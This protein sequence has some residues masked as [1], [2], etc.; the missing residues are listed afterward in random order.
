MNILAIDYGTKKSGIA[1]SIDGFVFAGEI[2]KSEQLISTIEKYITTKKIDH[3]V[4][5]MPYNIDGSISAH[6]LKV[7]KLNHK[8]SD[9]FPNT[10]ISL[11]DERCSTSEAMI[12]KDTH[13]V[14]SDNIDDIA[15]CIILEDY[16]THHKSTLL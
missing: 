15:A 14:E 12:W 16:I 2:I 4:L 8:L 10:T 3:I 6:G 9:I 1:Y 11:H 7:Q 5:W 13:Q